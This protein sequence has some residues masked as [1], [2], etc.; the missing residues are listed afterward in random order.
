MKKVVFFGFLLL[1]LLLAGCSSGNKS[2]TPATTG[3]TTKAEQTVTQTTVA[4]TVATTTTV[5]TTATTTTEAKKEAAWEI[6]DTSV[7]TWVSSI[8]SPWVQVIV[9]IEN[10]GDTNLYLSSGDCDIEDKDGKLVKAV[11]MVSAY[12]QI[13]AP[14]EIG[15]MYEE[16]MLDEEVKG[17]LSI[18][19]HP[20]VKETKLD[21]IRYDVS[22]V[23][24]KEDKYGYL[25]VSGRVENATK[26]DESS[27]YVVAFLYDNN[28]VLVGS[29]FTFVDLK[30]GEK[31][32]FEMSGMSLPKDITEENVSKIE[33]VAYPTQFDFSR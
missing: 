23:E 16:T 2:E 29:T 10:T 11:K 24:L 33:V 6:V 30:A 4:T 22:E 27:I 26:E 5:T 15:Y 25:K 13:I 1:S 28:E 31:R 21:L 19:P 20:E 18:I 17:E 9:S 32:G 3:T 12:P 7:K 14:G 8:G